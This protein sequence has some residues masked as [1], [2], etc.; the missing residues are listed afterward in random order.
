MFVVLGCDRD[1]NVDDG[2][3]FAFRARVRLGSGGGRRRDVGRLRSLRLV[4]RGCK[5]E[6]SVLLEDRL[7]QL[8]ERASGFDPKLVHEGAARVLVRV[9]G[10]G[11]PTRAIERQY[12]LGPKPLSQRMLGDGRLELADE[13]RVPT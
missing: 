2:H 7:V 4:A 12:Q 5:I 1:V 6:G 8:A 11:L 9:E 13:R 3:R 10:L